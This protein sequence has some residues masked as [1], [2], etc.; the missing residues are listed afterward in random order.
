MTRTVWL[1][2]ATCIL[3]TLG[4]SLSALEEREKA[5]GGKRDK[6]AGAAGQ[7]IPKEKAAGQ[8]EEMAVKPAANPEDVEAFRK[9]GD[10]AA[11]EIVTLHDEIDKDYTDLR[12]AMNVAMGDDKEAR[13]AKNEIKTLEAKIKRQSRKLKAAVEK[14]VL[15]IDRDYQATT[16]KYDGLQEKAKQFE[17][18]KQDKRATAT[19]QQADRYTAQIDAAKRTMEA[20]RS[21]LTFESAEGLELGDDADDARGGKAGRTERGGKARD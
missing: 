21:F 18:Q 19:Y 7:G 15:P 13:K 9:R 8:G 2:L 17:D 5:A 12:T 14:L 3:V 20:A 4:V 16:R 11:V 10:T 6:G 1:R